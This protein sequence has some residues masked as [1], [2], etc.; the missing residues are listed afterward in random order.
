MPRPRE[1]SLPYVTIDPHITTHPRMLAL[2][3]G[4]EDLTELP[5]TLLPMIPMRLFLLA[6]QSAVDGCLGDLSPKALRRIVA[7][8]FGIDAQSLYDALTSDDYGFLVRR[9]DGLHLHDWHDHAGQAYAKRAEWRDRKASTTTKRAAERDRKRRQR[10]GGTSTGQS[11]DIDGTK[12]DTRGKEAVLSR[13]EIDVSVNENNGLQY[14]SGKL[15][16]FRKIPPVKGKGKDKEKPQPN[17]PS[18]ELDTATRAR[19]DEGDGVGVGI[20]NSMPMPTALATVTPID[21]ARTSQAIAPT[22][23]PAAAIPDIGAVA[24]ACDATEDELSAN[25]THA[26]TSTRAQAKATPQKSSESNSAPIEGLNDIAAAV[27]GILAKTKGGSEKPT[28]E[29]QSHNGCSVAGEGGVNPPAQSCSPLPPL[30][31]R[32]PTDRLTMQEVQGYVIQRGAAFATV[33]LGRAMQAEVRRQAPTV[34]TLREALEAAPKTRG[35][36]VDTHMASILQRHREQCIQL[37]P[38]P[39]DIPR[40]V[41]ASESKCRPSTPEVEE[42]IRYDAWSTAFA[43]HGY[44]RDDARIAARAKEGTLETEDVEL[45]ERGGGDWAEY[46][47]VR[48]AVR[49]DG[50]RQYAEAMAKLMAG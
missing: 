16:E 42:R 26:E 35:P 19:D 6:G 36:R 32:P 17:P 21:Q 10:Q 24:M 23:A 37:E 22:K 4:L 25:E 50:R 3:D 1:T 43:R 18:T 44:P 2:I 31:S 9:D 40:T 12:P 38:K 45:I 27:A 8:E 28:P 47:R 15:G 41:P 5:A 39:A 34:A 48:A 33:G 30:D 46:D 49:E 29:T 20:D 7:P 13:S 14:S 11:R